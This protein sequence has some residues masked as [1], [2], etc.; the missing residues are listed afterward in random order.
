MLARTTDLGET[1]KTTMVEDNRNSPP[2]TPASA[3]GVT[4]LV[5]DT[6]GARDVVYV[7]YSRGYPDAPAGSP[8]RD[9]FLIVATSTDGGNS[10]S[11]GLNLNE[12]P[13]RPKVKIGDKDQSLVM[14]TGFGAPFMTVHNGTLLVVAGPDFPA[15]DAPSPPRTRVRA[16]APVPG[17]TSPCP[18]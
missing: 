7:R 8:L 6:S 13:N 18:S 12:N 9:P 3:T 1:W 10:F 16:A 14:R 4:G 15:G 2:P 11:P 17:S 5:V